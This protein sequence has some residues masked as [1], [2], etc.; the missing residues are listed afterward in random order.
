MQKN[1]NYIEQKSRIF[2]INFKKIGKRK[3]KLRR[4]ATEHHA[5]T[6]EF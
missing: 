5:G 1:H 6:V 3:S 4:K 2:K